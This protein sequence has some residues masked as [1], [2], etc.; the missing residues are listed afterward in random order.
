MTY[1][2]G[3]FKLE[4]DRL[5]NEDLTS[6]SAQVS[7]FSLEKLDLLAGAAA[8]DLQ[9]TVDYGVQIDIVLICHGVCLG[10]QKLPGWW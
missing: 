2:D 9:E 7:N 6:L 3:S 8:A 10:R 1:L 5:R 4:Q